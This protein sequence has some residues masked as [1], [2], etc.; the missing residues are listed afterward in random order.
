MRIDLKEGLMFLKA[1]AAAVMASLE[2]QL[3][4]QRCWALLISLRP[5]SRYRASTD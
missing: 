2:Q 1:L 4:P 3:T 5:A